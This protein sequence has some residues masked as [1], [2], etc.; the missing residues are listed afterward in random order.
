MMFVLGCWAQDPL[1]VVLG[2]KAHILVNFVILNVKTLH[3][4]VTVRVVVKES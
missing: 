3:F 2:L 4:V 1:R